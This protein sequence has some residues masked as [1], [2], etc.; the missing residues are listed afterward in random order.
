MISVSPVAAALPVASLLVDLENWVGGLSARLAEAVAGASDPVAVMIF[1]AAGVLASL[2]PCVYPMLPI[3]VTYMG[4]AE[5][6]AVAAGA[7]AEGR[8]K[9]IVMRSLAYVIGMALVYTAL[10]LAAVM[11]GRTFGAMTQ[12]PWAYGLV[13]VVMVIFALNLFGIFELRVPSFITDRLGTGPREGLGG[14]AIMGATSAIVAA[15]C[16]APIVFPLVT[17]V[18]T[19]GRVIFGAIA[20]LA[21]SL[22]LGLLFMLLGIFSGLAAS[23]PRPGGWM[24]TLKKVVG[25]LMLAIALYFFYLGY[26]RW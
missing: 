24:V 1:F 22:G 4:G 18:G 25:G 7:T 26:L 21:F 15:P 14:A 23:L 11:V 13:G 5:T 3:V 10:G 6:A 2:T 20:M 16:A 9:R 8:R 19:E 12:S 17:I